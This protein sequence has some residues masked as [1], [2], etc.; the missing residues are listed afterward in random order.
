MLPLL[1]VVHMFEQALNNDLVLTRVFEIYI[2][3]DLMPRWDRKV[4]T[5]MEIH[6]PFVS[7]FTST[8]YV[9]RSG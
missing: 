9:Y 2:E 8:S 3:K 6:G 4:K 7:L 5:C 1:N